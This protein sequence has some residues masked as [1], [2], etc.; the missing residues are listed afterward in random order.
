MRENGLETRL[1]HSEDDGAEQIVTLLRPI[2]ALMRM[3]NLRQWLSATP[4]CRS[5]IRDELLDGEKFY[6]LKEA[7]ILAGFRRI[8]G[9][10]TIE[11]SAVGRPTKST[12]I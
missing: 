8:S 11:A 12:A 10:T 6:S 9:P 4:G 3:A 7:Q 1:S 2:E 5:R